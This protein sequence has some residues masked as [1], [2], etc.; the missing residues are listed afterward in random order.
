MVK[1]TKKPGG[2]AL[3]P[4]LWKRIDALAEERG[5]SR[6]EVMESCL[7]TNLPVPSN[8]YNERV[9][10]NSIGLKDDDHDD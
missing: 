5:T 1:E 3:R 6:N 9:N 8:S 4:S 10:S 2:I 7:A